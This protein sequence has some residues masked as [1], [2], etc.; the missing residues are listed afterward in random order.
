[1]EDFSEFFFHFLKNI[2]EKQKVLD[3]LSLNKQS[4]LTLSCFNYKIWKK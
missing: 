1:M 3:L 2:L 4:A